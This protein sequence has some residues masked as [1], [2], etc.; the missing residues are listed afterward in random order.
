[1]N[2]PDGDSTPLRPIKWYKKLSTDKGRLEA[3]VFLVEGERAIKQILHRDA[4]KI[5]E[6]VTTEELPAVYRD[7]PARY[8]TDS[9]FRSICHSKT[10]QGPLAV[11]R[12]PPDIYSDHLPVDI[13]DRV[14]LLE[15]VQDPGN[16]GTLIRTAAALDFSGVIL[17]TKCA[18]LLSPKCA[19]STAGSVLSVW[20]RRTD[21]YLDLVRTLQESGYAIVAADLNG[22]Q[23]VTIL[24]ERDKIVLT[25]GNEASGLSSDVLNAADYR[26]KIPVNRDKAESL[27]VAACGAICMFL[28]SRK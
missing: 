28:S 8:I 24:N 23:D 14:L 7:Y 15:D 10:P 16:V 18:D 4:D 5:I 25:L 12:M 21:R 2:I 20:V 11:V 3:G 9:Q 19:Q 27:N 26:I 17:S 1:L 6:I 22:E 13:G